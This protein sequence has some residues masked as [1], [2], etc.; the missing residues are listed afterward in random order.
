MAADPGSS[1]TLWDGLLTAASAVFGGGVT[2]GLQRGRI[3]AHNERLDDH[4]ARLSAL[5]NGSQNHATKSDIMAIAARI[6]RIYEI[7]T[8]KSSK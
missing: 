4:G 7:L 6:D 2:F 5:E 8:G 1:W 3:L